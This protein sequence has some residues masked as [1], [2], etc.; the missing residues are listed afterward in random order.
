M[1]GYFSDRYGNIALIDRM[2]RTGNADEPCGIPACMSC[3]FPVLPS[4]RTIADLSDRNE[5]I[6]RRI[7]WAMPISIMCFS[8]CRSLAQAKSFLVSSSRSIELPEWSLLSSR[9]ED[10]ILMRCTR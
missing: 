2:N 3:V 4:M 9:C 7:L 1:S 6:Q 8:N 10:N 5:S